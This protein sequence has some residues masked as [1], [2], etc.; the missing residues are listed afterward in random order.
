M[1]FAIKMI[2]GAECPNGEELFER[3][4]KNISNFFSKQGLNITPSKLRE[5]IVRKT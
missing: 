3:D 5:K 1:A 4:I 2:A